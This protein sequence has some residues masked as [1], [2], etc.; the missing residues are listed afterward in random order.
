[1]WGMAELSTTICGVQFPN[2]VWT[3]AGPGGADGEMLL[4]AA[5]GGAGGLVAKTISVRPADVPAPNIISPFPGSLLNAELWSEIPFRRFIDRELP[6]A[7][8]AGIPVV[9][10]VGYTAEELALLGAELEKAG[11]ADAVEF[12]IHYVG[13]DPETL[14]SLAGALKRSVSVPVLAKLSPGVSDLDAVVRTL[15]E[16]VDGFVAVN[17]VGP[18]LDFDLE[19]G[20][21]LLGSRDGRG[22]L[23]GGA[24]LPVGLH[25][26]AAISALTTKPVIGVGGVRTAKDV[27]KYLMAGA[28][29]VQVCSLA[30]LKGQEVYGRLA[31]GLSDWMDGHGYVSVGELRGLYARR[32]GERER[33]WRA[34]ERQPRLFP[35][36]DPEVCTHCLLCERSCIHGAIQFEGERYLLDREACVRCGLCC[37]LCP[38]RALDMRPEEG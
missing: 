1:M 20:R 11:V 28:S 25:F 21:P 3:A 36:I 23:S 4:R 35:E 27:V 18:A 8:E 34:S 24:I 33:E 37:S 31:T 2:P 13:K 17:S 30:V 38:A 22:W 15:E 9:A 12:S 6:R 19:S 7:R 16:T 10:S 29:A 14:R 32:L 5:R 26:V